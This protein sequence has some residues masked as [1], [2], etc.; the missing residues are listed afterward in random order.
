MGLFSKDIEGMNDLFEHQMKD[1]Y[2]AEK[3]I[4]GALPKMI[5]KANSANLKQG[6]ETH[7]AETKTHITRLERVFSMH[8]IE[9]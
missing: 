2:Y 1:I 9:A 4:A 7:P 6:F 3:R 5:E 8:G